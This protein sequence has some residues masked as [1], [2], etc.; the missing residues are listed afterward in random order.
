MWPLFPAGSL[1]ILE[2]QEND[3]GKYECVAENSAGTEYSQ[4]AQLYVRGKLNYGYQ[5][6]VG[7]ICFASLQ[8]ERYH[9]ISPFLRSR[10]TRSCPGLVST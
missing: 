8:Y 3:Q 7:N 1:Q 4:S 10:N 9:H 5:G 6:S 2:S